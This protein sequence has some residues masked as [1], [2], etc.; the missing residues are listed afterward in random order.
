MEEVDS[1]IALEPK[2]DYPL[3]CGKQKSFNGHNTGL[4]SDFIWD[5]VLIPF[6][7]LNLHVLA[8]LK[9]KGS[10]RQI[11]FKITKALNAHCYLV[12]LVSKLGRYHAELSCSHP[13]FVAH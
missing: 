4:G 7:C 11:T 9:S 13:S 10:S 5:G 8:A 1:F 6:L 2:L 12:P 3:A